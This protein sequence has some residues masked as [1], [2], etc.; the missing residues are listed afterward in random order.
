MKSRSRQDLDSCFTVDM[1]ITWYTSFKTIKNCSTRVPRAQTRGSW[2]LVP[3]L[4]RSNCHCGN[5]VQFC[6]SLTSTLSLLLLYYCQLQIL[7]CVASMFTNFCWICQISLNFLDQNVYNSLFYSLFFIHDNDRE[8][9][10]PFRLHF[11]GLPIPHV[12]LVG[13]YL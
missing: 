5:D 13:L 4:V 8:V 12:K 10:A 2:G 6:L 3:S 1:D 7:H 9:S 11:S